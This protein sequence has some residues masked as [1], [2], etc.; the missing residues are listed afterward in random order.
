MTWT[1]ADTQ[2][3]VWLLWALGGS[4]PTSQE[5]GLQA[6]PWRAALPQGPGAF[7]WVCDTTTALQGGH[8]TQK[9]QDKGLSKTARP[10]DG[11]AQD[12]PGLPV[13]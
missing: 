2:V 13:S 5:A 1:Q 4:A 10:E 7:Y 8:D 3:H 12:G 9:I 11:R 6:G